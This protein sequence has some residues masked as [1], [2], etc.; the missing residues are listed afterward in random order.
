MNH[1]AMAFSHPS[2]H[3]G[4][5]TRLYFFARS[6]YAPADMQE[7]NTAIMFVRCKCESDDCAIKSWTL[8]NDQIM[9]RAVVGTGL[10][11]VGTGQSSL[12]KVNEDDKVFALGICAA[13]LTHERWLNL[14]ELFDQAITEGLLGRL[15]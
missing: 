1:F 10:Y 6:E 9:E 5:D 2:P 12:T 15:Q 4:I 14:S 11:M 13:H 8:V 7:G 3:G